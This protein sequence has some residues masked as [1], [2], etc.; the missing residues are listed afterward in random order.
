MSNNWSRPQR[1]RPVHVRL[2]RRRRDRRRRLARDHRSVPT[3]FV[4]ANHRARVA[5]RE[6]IPTYYR[7]LLVSH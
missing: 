1:T 6:S 5:R 7:R 4:I 2:H 3:A